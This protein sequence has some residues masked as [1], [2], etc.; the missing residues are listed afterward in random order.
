MALDC[1]ERHIEHLFG[2]NLGADS[3]CTELHRLRGTHLLPARRTPVDVCA[4]LAAGEVTLRGLETRAELVLELHAEHRRQLDG[5]PVVLEREVVLLQVAVGKAEDILQ[6]CV[7]GMAYLRALEKARASLN[8]RR[9][10][11]L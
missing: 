7:V 11:E 4:V 3:G 9:D 2:L 6:V 8:G 1:V 5:A 10:D